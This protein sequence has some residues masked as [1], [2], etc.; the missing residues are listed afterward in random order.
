MALIYKNG[1]YDLLY[2]KKNIELNPELCLYDKNLVIKKNKFHKRVPHE[3]P[4]ERNDSESKAN[5][6][7]PMDNNVEGDSDDEEGI[8][9]RRKNKKKAKRKEGLYDLA[10]SNIVI[11]NK[12]DG[13]EPDLKVHDKI[14]EKSNEGSDDEDNKYEKEKD[15]NKNN[16]GQESDKSNDESNKSEENKDKNNK[17]K[18]NKDESEDNKEAGSNNFSCNIDEDRNKRVEP[19]VEYDRAISKFV[20]QPIKP[21]KDNRDATDPNEIKVKIDE[22]DNLKPKDNS[23][24]NNQDVCTGNSPNAAGE[25]KIITNDSKDNESN[26]TNKKKGDKTCGCLLL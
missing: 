2:H 7:G 21:V 4:P 23:S 3:N 8:D 12:E 19:N 14:E 18:E 22:E 9:D 6:K 24:Q 11:N 15:K 13:Q 1:H 5:K 20:N 25:N 10:V 17:S 16:E 26:K